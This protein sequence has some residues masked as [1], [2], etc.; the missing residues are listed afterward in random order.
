MEKSG[1]T[2]ENYYSSHDV[3][4]QVTYK[5]GALEGP[6]PSEPF[7]VVLQDA[8]LRQSTLR[9]SNYFITSQLY[10]ENKPLTLPIRTS[11][12]LSE[13]D[14]RWDQWVTF[15]LK[16]SD[17]PLSSQ[18]AITVWRTYAPRKAAPIGGTTFK[19]FGKHS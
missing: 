3:A 11:R 19:L 18:I 2:G 16:Y 6:L 13:E 1:T 9:G 8:F 17:L 12:Q 5:I 14:G 15:P 4:L 7:G 10:A